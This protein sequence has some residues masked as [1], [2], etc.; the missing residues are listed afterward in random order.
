MN[1]DACSRSGIVLALLAVM[2]WPVCYLT[3]GGETS[4]GQS[5]TRQHQEQPAARATGCDCPCASPDHSGKAFRM[6]IS[7]D[8]PPFSRKSRP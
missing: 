3:G 4:D 7:P 6:G 5:T 1:G 8:Q 2:A